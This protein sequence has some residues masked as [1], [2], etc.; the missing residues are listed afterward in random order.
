L[1]QRRR[2]VLVMLAWNMEI[3]TLDMANEEEQSIK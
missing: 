3:C 1:R 2:R